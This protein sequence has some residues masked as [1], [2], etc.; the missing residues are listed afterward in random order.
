MKPEIDKQIGAAS[1][2]KQTLHRSIVDL[3]W[4]RALGRDQKEGCCPRELTP[5]KR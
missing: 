1:A 2:V 5:D 3:L 4:S